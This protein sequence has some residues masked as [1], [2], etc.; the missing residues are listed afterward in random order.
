MQDPASLDPGEGADALAGEEA[1]SALERAER[2]VEAEIE[3]QKAE[4][5]QLRRQFDA[6]S[7]RLAED[8]RLAGRVQR[9]CSRARCCIRGWTWRGSSSPSARWAATTT[10]W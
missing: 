9:G 1:E 8:L 5:S 10:T 6:L 2:A 4:L 3:R 7:S